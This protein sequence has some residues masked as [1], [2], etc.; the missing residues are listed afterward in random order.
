MWRNGIVK[1]PSTDLWTII[2][3][4]ALA[5]GRYLPADKI[6]LYGHVVRGSN[7]NTNSPE[8]DNMIVRH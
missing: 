1:D 4:N 7:A 6:V 2:L 8:P 3:V 5:V